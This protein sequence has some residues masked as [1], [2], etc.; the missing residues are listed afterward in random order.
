MSG[1]WNRTRRGW[2]FGP[3]GQGEKSG[4][5]RRLGRNSDTY[6]GPTLDALHAEKHGTKKVSQAL[7]AQGATTKQGRY[8]SLGGST[9]PTKGTARRLLGG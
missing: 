4:A 7:G 9:A 5:Q 6:Y 8:V 3:E 2:G 1:L